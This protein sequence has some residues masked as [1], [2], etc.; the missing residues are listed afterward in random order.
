VCSGAPMGAT[1]QVPASVSLANGVPSPFTASVSTSGGAALPPTIRLRFEPFDGVRMM[2]LAMV[3]LMLL[4]HR[5]WFEEASYAR[6]MALAGALVAMVTYA[7]L[8][9]G[10]CSGGSSAAL[11][12][13]PPPVLTPAGISTIV[14]TPTAMSSTGQ[15]LQLPPIQLTLTVN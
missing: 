1:C 2:V 12:T 15:P 13:P 7:A 3:L 6:R 14:I 10:G 9:M 5:R 11:V 8:S 4:A